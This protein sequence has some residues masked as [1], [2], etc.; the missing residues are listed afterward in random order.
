LSA[1]PEGVTQATLPDSAVVDLP[2]VGLDSPSPSTPETITGSAVDTISAVDEV[3]TAETP[4]I[5]EPTNR[6]IDHHSCV[7]TSSGSINSYSVAVVANSNTNHKGLLLEKVAKYAPEYEAVFESS[8]AALFLSTVTVRRKDGQVGGGELVL[9]GQEASTKK[10]AEQNVSFAMLN[11]T[12]FQA[13]C[14]TARLQLLPTVASPS[15]LTMALSIP[16]GSVTGSFI[17]T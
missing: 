7:A 11:Y 9:T 6:S 1:E 10:Q 12:E 13:F 4:L 14:V 16:I 8:R 17:S 15:L 5:T 2:P 3:T